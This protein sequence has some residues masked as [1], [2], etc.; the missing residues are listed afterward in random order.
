MSIMTRRKKNLLPEAT[1]IETNKKVLAVIDICLTKLR[2]TAISLN[3]KSKINKL[4][5]ILKNLKLT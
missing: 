4:H 1:F 3:F 5:R 2:Q